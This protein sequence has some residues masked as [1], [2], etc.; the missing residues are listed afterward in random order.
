[1][2][3]RKQI[4]LLTLAPDSWTQQKIASFLMWNFV[5]LEKQPHRKKNKTYCQR[6]QEKGHQLDDNVVNLVK[7]F[8]EDDEYSSMCPR[9]KEYKSVTIHGV[10]RKKQEILLLVNMKELYLE[11]WK[12]YVNNSQGNDNPKIH[13]GLSKFF[14]LRRKW[15]VTAS[16]SC[17]NNVCVHVQSIRLLN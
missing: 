15:V 12:K 11:F 17:M 14:S 8:Y 13:I 9:A 7:Q 4:P 2:A 6:Y 1:M 10:K 3:K 16:D 5:V